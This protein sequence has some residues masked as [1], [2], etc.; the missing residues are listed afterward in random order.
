MKK[1]KYK[2]F[3]NRSISMIQCEFWQKGE[4]GT[5]KWTNNEFFFSP[6]FIHKEGKGTDIYYDF[7]DPKQDPARLS[8]FVDKHSD[9]FFKLADEYEKNCDELVGLVNK[10]NVRDF[11][12]IYKLVLKIWPIRISSSTLAGI[13]ADKANK[14]VVERS[15]GLREKYD[16]LSY[17]AGY[18]LVDLAKEKIPPKYLPYIEFVTFEEITGKLPDIKELEKR[19]KGFLLYSGKIIT[20]DIE[21]FLKKK[22][23]ELLEEEKAEKSS[24][25]KGSTANKGLAK[26]KAKIVFEES[27]LSK[28][29]EGDILIATMTTPNFLPAMQKASGFVTDEG[30]LLCHA[31]IVAREMN[32]PCVVGT[33]IATKSLKDGDMIEVDASKGIITILKKDSIAEKIK[34]IEWTKNWEGEFSILSA[35]SPTG[36]GVY[37][38]DMKRYFGVNVQHVLVVHRSGVSTCYIADKDLHEFGEGLFRKVKQNPLLIEEW[39]D[40]LKKETDN[41][42][43]ISKM[44]PEELLDSKA[45][46]RF[47]DNK[48]ELSCYQI[49]LKQLIDNFSPEFFEK[50]GH[51]IEK[52]RRYSEMVYFEIDKI[53]SS[54]LRIISKRTEVEEKYLSCLKFDEMIDY[55]ENGSLPDLDVLKQRYKFS[56]YLYGDEIKEITEP[57]MKEI[58][59]FWTKKVKNLIGKSAFPGIVRGRCRVIIDYKKANLEKGD[60]LV[61]GMTDPNFVPLMKKAGAIVTDAG[62]ILCHAAIVSRELHIPCVIGTKVATKVL[63]D[64]DLVEVDA[65]KGIVRKI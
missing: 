7:S 54:M 8:E 21:G 26:G 31:A 37:N 19:K 27:Q 59:D 10:K 3:L 34:K 1:T 14:K 60:I 32:K 23:I 48:I 62:G 11:E 33:R 56:A 29:K 41:I 57:D 30:G 9:V 45:F 63:K 15:K 52:A 5:S 12:K 49:A 36:V 17:N 28:V 18:T 13:L 61:T 43:K 20:E 64:G 38:K 42:F 16:K 53:L 24:V 35:I 51:L 39:C 6:I 25:I 4:E 40:K 46:R 2:K 22:S 55:L 47:G 65:N 58:E 44:P 50:Y